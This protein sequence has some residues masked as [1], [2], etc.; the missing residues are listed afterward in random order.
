MLQP[1]TTSGIYIRTTLDT[2]TPAINGR[3]EPDSR[4]DGDHTEDLL[5]SPSHGRKLPKNGAATRWLPMVGLAKHP[6]HHRP[7][8]PVLLAVD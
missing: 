3:D 4:H 5:A 2:S 8:R 6:D 1:M 7:E